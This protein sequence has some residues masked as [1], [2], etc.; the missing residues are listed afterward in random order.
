MKQQTKTCYYFRI[1]TEIYI[2]FST[3]NLDLF[4]FNIQFNIYL[5]RLLLFI[6]SH[7]KSV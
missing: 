1:T 2:Y 6:Q 3:P 5:F 7:T 4:K